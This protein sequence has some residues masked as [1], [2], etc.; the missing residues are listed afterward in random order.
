MAVQQRQLTLERFLQL[1]EEEPALEFEEGVAIQKVS[2]KG[3]HS[4]LQ[5]R[6]AELVNRAAEPQR[7]T[8]AFP[9]LR[10]TFGGRSYVPDVSIFRWERIPVD[11][12]GRL[13]NDFFDPS[14][15]A[16]EIIS[17]QQSANRVFRRCLWY[18]QRGVGV[19]LRVDPGDESVLVFRPGQV[20]TGQRGPDWI[21]LDEVLP[22]FALSVNE[23]F[24]SFR[25]R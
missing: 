8:R 13:G 17:P 14:D 2:P 21:H 1:P 3:Q 16:I 22:G 12:S 20:P 23:L 11:E 6:I 10:T 18:V 19:A 9:E 25:M 5:Y 24:E 7:Q 15:V 4:A